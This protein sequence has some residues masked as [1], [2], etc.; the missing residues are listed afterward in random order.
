MAKVLLTFPLVPPRA[1]SI[2]QCSHNKARHGDVFF[3]AA[4]PSLQSRA[5]W[6]RYVLGGI[7]AQ[8][9]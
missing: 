5:C 6:R 3:V 8:Q 9:N 2:G 1:I 7:F 4:S